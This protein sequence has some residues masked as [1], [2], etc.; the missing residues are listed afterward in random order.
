M[1]RN[2][3]RASARTEGDGEVA[4]LPPR[5]DGTPLRILVVEDEGFVALDVVAHLADCG[6]DARVA[7]TTRTALGMLAELQPDL[8]LLDVRLPDGDGVELAAA[9]RALSDVPII[10]VTGIATPATLRRVHSVGSFPVISKPV[11]LRELRA[12]ILDVLGRWQR[13][14]QRDELIARSR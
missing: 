6:A 8:V 9:M 4:L 14:R 13:D 10:F 2:V 3:G 1:N 7:P 12:S 5:S 11:N